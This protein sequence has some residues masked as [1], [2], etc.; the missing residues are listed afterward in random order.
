[1]PSKEY[2]QGRRLYFDKKKHTKQ[3]CEEKKRSP[4]FF[5]LFDFFFF[6]W[7]PIVGMKSLGKS[8]CHIS[9]AV[10]VA[11]YSFHYFYFYRKL[12]VSVPSPR[13]FVFSLLLSPFVSL[14]FK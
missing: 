7:S 13:F 12:V 5:F 9:C 1:M 4:F 3:E 2:D 14:F 11:S 10:S 8:E 6:F